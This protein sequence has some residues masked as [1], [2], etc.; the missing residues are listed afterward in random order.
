MTRSSSSKRKKLVRKHSK[1]SLMRK[2]LTL[3]HATPPSPVPME[4]GDEHLTADRDEV[5]DQEH[6][7]EAEQHTVSFLLSMT[8]LSNRRVYS[9]GVF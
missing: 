6:N 4:L 2:K 8:C 5:V 7:D 1:L 3:W 9:Y